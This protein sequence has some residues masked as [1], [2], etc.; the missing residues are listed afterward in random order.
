MGG[1]TLSGQVMA[2]IQAGVFEFTVRFYSLPRV[3]KTVRSLVQK[4]LPPRYLNYVL[5]IL[6]S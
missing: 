3:F 1:V 6:T 2:F 5:G 4:I